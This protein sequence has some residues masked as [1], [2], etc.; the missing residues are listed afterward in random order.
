MELHREIKVFV[1][2]DGELQFG[3]EVTLVAVLYGYDDVLYEL[4]W[5]S[6]SDGLTWEAVPG[7]NELAYTMIVSEENYLNSW[8]VLVTV[9]GPRISD[10]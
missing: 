10:E 4:Q 6:S 1:Q 2:Y 7:A 9:I 3:T 5:E 8:H